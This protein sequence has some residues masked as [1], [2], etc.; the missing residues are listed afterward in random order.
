MPNETDTTPT[1]SLPATPDSLLSQPPAA[2]Q[3]QPS[4]PTAQTAAPQAP[5][6]KPDWLDQRFWKNGKIDDESLHK[7]YRSMETLLGKKAQAVVPINDKSTPEDIAAWRKATGVPQEPDGYKIKPETLPEGI[8]Y[9]E[10]GMKRFAEFAHKHNIPES[11]AKELVAYH[12]QQQVAFQQATEQVLTK[13]RAEAK[14]ELKRTWGTAYDAKIDTAKRAVLTVGGDP[15]S[16][17]FGDPTVIKA[18]VA[19]AEKLS[20]DQLVSSPASTAN[21]S[22]EA[23][24]DIMTN[25]NNPLHERYRQGDPEIVERTRAMLTRKV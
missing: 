5:A 3:A 8:V 21:G 18:F 2:S 24:R 1:P 11:T 16:F 9:D 17:G 22:K 10:A 4:E 7:S 15:N 19:L 14:E 20:D 13:E 25:P 23:A 6:E 12:M